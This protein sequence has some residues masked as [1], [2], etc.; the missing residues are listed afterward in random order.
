MGRKGTD[1][2]DLGQAIT[3]CMDA[4]VSDT[5]ITYDGDFLCCLWKAPNDD[6]SLWLITVDAASSAVTEVPHVAV[7]EKGLT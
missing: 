2:T 6:Y 7:H 3:D 1:P 5:M 4:R